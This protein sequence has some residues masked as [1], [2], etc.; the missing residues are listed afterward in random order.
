[1]LQ[2]MSRTI[3][4]A[5]WLTI[6]ESAE[7]I[8]RSRTILAKNIKAYEQKIGR[9]LER[10]GDGQTKLLRKSDIDAMMLALPSLRAEARRRGLIKE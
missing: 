8:N 5:E 2:T 4:G 9:E 1:M 6:G 7:Y 10:E 3:N